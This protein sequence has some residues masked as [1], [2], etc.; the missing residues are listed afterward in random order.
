MRCLAGEK[1]GRQGKRRGVSGEHFKITFDLQGR[2]VSEVT[3]SYGT[4]VSYDGQARKE[5]GDH[6]TWILFS[7]RTIEVNVFE[8]AFIFEL[9]SASHR[10]CQGEYAANVQSYMAE[11]RNAPPPGLSLLGLQSHESTAPPTRLRTPSQ[12][13]IYILGRQ[14]GK[15]L[16]GKVHFA[17]DVGTGQE[18][19]AKVF[20]AGWKFEREVEIF[21]AN[22]PCENPVRYSS[23]LFSL[24]HSIQ[25]HMVQFVDF[26]DKPCPRLIME[27]LPLGD[28]DARHQRKNPMTVK[29]IVTVFYQNLQA[30]AHLRSHGPGFTHQDIKPQNILV[31]SRA[32]AFFS[33]SV[34]GEDRQGRRVEESRRLSTVRLKIPAGPL[35]KAERAIQRVSRAKVGREIKGQ[36]GLN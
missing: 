34:C 21:E 19:A 28:L 4:A 33:L 11:R 22:F 15:G 30:L 8:K 27:Y 5:R 20:N 35:T 32:R 18:Y 7:G 16:C 31:Q 24:L 9:I 3:S 29:E 6:F 13:P 17:E 1:K 2:L 12:Q 25:D 14:L 36:N 23:P 10:T 26:D